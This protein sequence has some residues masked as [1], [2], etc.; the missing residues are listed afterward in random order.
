MSGGLIVFTFMVCAAVFLVTALIA[1]EIYCQVK[2]V[3]LAI[4]RGGEE[5]DK[6]QAELRSTSGNA[7]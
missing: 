7:E 3:K 6:Q 2:R 5:Y 4:K 1:S